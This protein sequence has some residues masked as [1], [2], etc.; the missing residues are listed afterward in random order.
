MF[1][2]SPMAQP[3]RDDV[4]A[5]T[6][7]YLEAA[8]YLAGE[9]LPIRRA[10]LAQWLGISAPSVTEAV[11]RLIDEGLLEAGPGRQLQLTPK[12]HEMAALVVRRHRIVEA[13]AVLSLG[14][15]WVAADEEAQ[16]LAPVVSDRILD[17]LHETIG[18]PSCCPHGNPVPGEPVP[19]SARSTRRLVDLGPGEQA[20]VVRISELAEHDAHDVLDE[21][22]RARLIPTTPITVVSVDRD[23]TMVLEVRGRQHRVRGRVASA[24]WVTDPGSGTRRPAA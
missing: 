18:R 15:D 13:W 24:V 2:V 7:R 3:V 14:L 19:A 6:L 22:Y 8:Y 17:R 11:G 23:G 9:G 21:A 5:A 10:R 1:P 4:S 16:R 12:G 20:E